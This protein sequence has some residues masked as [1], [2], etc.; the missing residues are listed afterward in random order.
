[1]KK[2][3]IILII[4]VL[5]FT[6]LGLFWLA[7]GIFLF[8]IL[9]IVSFILLSQIRLTIV[10]RVIKSILIFT[11]ILIIIISIKVFAFDIFRVPSSSMKNSLFPNDVIIVN[12][13][14][15]GPRLP[16]SPFDIPFVHIGYY[17]NE[18]AIKRI[19]EYWWPYKRLSGMTLSREKRKRK[20]FV[21]FN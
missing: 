9:C 14:K 19:K 15:Y 13:L 8:S 16:H 21:V 7:V 11:G 10:K 4:V 12:K 5:I 1:M 3:I 20:T 18:N 17:F 6:V 2:S